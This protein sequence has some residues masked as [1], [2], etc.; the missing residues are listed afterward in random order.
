MEIGLLKIYEVEEDLRPVHGLYGEMFARLLREGGLSASWREYDVRAGELPQTTGECDGWLITGSKHAVYED[1]EWLPPLFGFIRRLRDA[2][3]PRV[4]GV[5]FGHQAVAAALGGRAEKSANGWGSGRQQWQIC[6]DAEWMRP[7]PAEFSLLASHQ[8]QVAELPPGA[9]LLA[10]SEF[11]PIAMFAVGRQFFC[12]QG[13]PEFSPAFSA[14]ILDSR[15]ET[16][17]PEVW[18]RAVESSPLPNDRAICAQWLAQ[19]FRE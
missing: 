4:A 5:C 2:G 10:A 17:P 15:R 12:M 7:R 13:H 9:E 6:G 16:M 19:F 11:C 14:A 1:H 8:D 18:Q 3:S